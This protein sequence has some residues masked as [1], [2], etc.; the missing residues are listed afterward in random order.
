MYILFLFKLF[1]NVLNYRLLQYAPPRQE[2]ILQAK[3]K[4]ILNTFKKRLAYF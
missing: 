3:N 1:L 2:I 4:Q